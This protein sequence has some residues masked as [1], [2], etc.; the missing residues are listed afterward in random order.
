M[1]KFALIF[2]SL[3]LL[4]GCSTLNGSV[5]FHYVPSLSSMHQNSAVLGME[6]FVDRRPA[7]DQEATKS[8]PDIDEKIT[9]KVLDDLKSSRMF[10]DIHFPARNNEDNLIIKGEIKR[11][12]WKTKHNPIKF[13]PMVQMLLLL[14]ITSHNVEAVVELKVQL[15][16]AKTGAVLSEYDKTSIKTDSATLYVNTSGESGSEL[17]EAF[18][19]VVKQ[20]KDSLAADI[21]TK[22]I[23]VRTM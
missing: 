13:I 6:K 22:K 9:A 4:S 15:L 23:L 21:Q 5:P 20:I 11:F 7:E 1:K 16:D 8:I 14:G 19:D 10:A 18:R 12:Y 3:F 17:A 2:C